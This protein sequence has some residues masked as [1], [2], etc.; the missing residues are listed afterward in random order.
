MLAVQEQLGYHRLHHLH[1]C[2]TFAA[3]TAVVAFCDTAVST[4][5]STITS[6]V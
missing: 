1:P 5:V 6:A 4:W 2:T 3:A